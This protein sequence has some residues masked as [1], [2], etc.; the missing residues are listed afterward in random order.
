MRWHKLF[1]TIFLCLTVLLGRSQNGATDYDG[2]W[3]VVDS[4]LNFA[5]LPE[6]ALAEVGRI[7]TLAMQEHNRSQEVK[8]LIYRLTIQQQKNENDDT[9]DIR[10]ME[11]R[12]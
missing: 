4:L 8:A 3:R 2:R 12:L 9:A 10:S 5:G 1:G 6:S 11:K 7:D